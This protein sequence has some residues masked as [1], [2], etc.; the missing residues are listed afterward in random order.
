MIK[1]KKYI[2]IILLLI[3]IFNVC[4]VQVKADI[5]D[6]L[7]H[8]FYLFI[9]AF[10]A[11][12]IMT[13]TR[14]AMYLFDNYIRG[15]NAYEVEEFKNNCKS[16]LNLGL[17]DLTVMGVGFNNWIKD[18]FKKGYNREVWNDSSGYNIYDYNE[19]TAI[20]LDYENLHAGYKGIYRINGYYISIEIEEYNSSYYYLNFDMCGL[21][22]GKTSHRK[23]KDIFIELNINGTQISLQVGRWIQGDNRYSYITQY[24][25]TNTMPYPP[26]LD[27]ND[28]D[29]EI[30]YYAGEAVDYPMNE[31]PEEKPLVLPAPN[32]D[33]TRFRYDDAGNKVFDGTIDQFL[34]AAF[35]HQADY[36]D[37]AAERLLSG[38]DTGVRAVV[39]V[40]AGTITWPRSGVIGDVGVDIPDITY[41]DNVTD[42]VNEQTGVIGSIAQWLSN[43]FAEPSVSFNM[44]PLMQFNIKDKFPFCLPFD[45]AYIISNLSSNAEIPKFQ[46]KFPGPKNESVEY[47]MNFEMFEP[48]AVILRSL[49]VLSYVIGLVLISRKLIGGE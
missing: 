23:D 14:S 43:V 45:L 3:I 36:L 7:R 49:I 20:T 19:S 46:L 41:P 48:V 1:Y 11:Y 8:A 40:G 22:V 34:D 35:E 28:E 17:I 38:V 37:I 6:T 12:G 33:D 44:S 42:A 24:I 5:Q 16:V 39:D 30:V 31:Y 9:A 4:Y 18:T 26:E 32:F 13:N 15:L 29:I 47:E 21:N 2:S 10:N 27:I 25:S